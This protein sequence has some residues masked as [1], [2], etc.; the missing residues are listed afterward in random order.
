MPASA[1][2]KLSVPNYRIDAD[3]SLNS[4]R[5][6]RDQSSLSCAGDKPSAV[7]HA[8]IGKIV[9]TLGKHDQ[10]RLLSCNPLR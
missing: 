2:T 1:V 8:G 10:F 6:Y 4:D 7:D 3:V 9:M 5:N